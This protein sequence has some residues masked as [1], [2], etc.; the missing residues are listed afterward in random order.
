MTRST[1][2][3]MYVLTAGFGAT[4]AMWLVG[5]LGHVPPLVAPGPVLLGLMLGCLLGAGAAAGR[6]AGANAIG[7]ALV[8]L[9]SAAVNLLILGSVIA[10]APGAE[11]RVPPGLVWIPG[12]FLL[13]AATASIGAELARR[14]GPRP[15][16]A[17]RWRSGFVAVAFIA[18]LLVVIAG[19]L[20]TSLEAGLAVPDWPNTFRTNM[21]LYPLSRMTGGIYYEHAHRLYGALVGLTTIV[22]AATLVATERRRKWIWV[23]AAL[24]VAMVMVQGVMGG[25]RVID[26]SVPFAISHG[27]FGQV[28]LATVGLVWAFTTAT[29]RDAPKP[30]PGSSGADRI[31]TAILLG[32]TV[33]QVVLGAMY[34]HTATAETPLPGSGLAHFTLSVFVAGFAVI[35]GLRALTDKKGPALRRRLGGASLAIVALQLALG[36]AALIPLMARRDDWKT[37]E[38][39]LATAHQANGALF[40]AV[41]VQLFAWARRLGPCA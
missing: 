17:A 4:V 21:F 22:L 25:L 6:Y 7:G 9:V 33:A 19:G 23:V 29:W 40:L 20:V 34:R 11:G 30:Q 27:V 26:R 5:Y 41:V 24:V 14:A 1:S 16:P 35:A 10:D 39:V 15:V 37:I 13:S 12:S 32:V 3:R 2:G 8:G 28:F 38:V 36:V 18:T 31:L